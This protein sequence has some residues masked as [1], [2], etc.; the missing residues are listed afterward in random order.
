MGEHVGLEAVSEPSEGSVQA[1]EL[2][3]SEEQVSVMFIA[4]DEPAK[5]LQPGDAPLDRP[6]PLVAAEL[7]TI[8]QLR[9][10]AAAAVR[11]DQVDAALRQ[12]HAQGVAVGRLVV[13]QPLRPAMQ[14][15][16]GQQRL[17]QADLRRTRAVDLRREGQSAAIGQ[18]HELGAF[19]TLGLTDAVAPFFAAANVPSA[20]VSCQFTCPRPSSLRS[21]RAQAFSKVPSSLHSFSRRQQV[22]YEGKVFGKSFHLAPVLSTHRIP[23]RQGR[24]GTRG[25]PPA[26]VGGSQGN[27]SSITAHCSSESCGFVAVFGS[28]PS[29]GSVL[30]AVQNRRTDGHHTNVNRMSGSPF[31]PTPTQFTRRIC[32]LIQRF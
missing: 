15:A 19:T 30:D 3:E 21:E 7:A 12:P 23:S 24:G 8:L 26:A 28:S 9:P 4:D 13:D 1:G 6:A 32:S 10:H 20:K 18:E 29:P 22:G 11:A 25:R 27:R 14:D 16:F 31:T 5:V 17:D 2:N